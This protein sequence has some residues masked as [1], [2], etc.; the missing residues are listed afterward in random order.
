VG[1][2]SFTRTV[3]KAIVPVTVGPAGGRFA[4]GQGGGVGTGTFVGSGTPGVI[5]NTGGGE[6][7]DGKGNT[8]PM[9]VMSVAGRLPEYGLLLVL[10]GS[11]SIVSE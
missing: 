2:T 9:I 3:P 10:S 11:S 7:G 1:T 5:G 6:G 8:V 4:G